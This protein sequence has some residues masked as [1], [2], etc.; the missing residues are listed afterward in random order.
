MKLNSISY[1]I[2]IYKT[3]FDEL[4]RC[5][6]HIKYQNNLNN[7]EIQVVLIFDGP[8]LWYG[9]LP[10]YLNE[11]TNLGI[12]VI[13]KVLESNVGTFEARKLGFLLSTGD[14]IFELDPD[15]TLCNTTTDTVLTEMNKHKVDLYA[16]TL[17]DLCFGEVVHPPKKLKHFRNYK[18]GSKITAGLVGT[19]KVFTKFYSTIDTPLLGYIFSEDVLAEVF[20]AWTNFR[21]YGSKVPSYIYYSEGIS[22]NFS[23]SL[24]FYKEQIDRTI[25]LTK[26]Y[27]TK[28]EA[29]KQLCT[30]L[31]EEF[32]N[33]KKSKEVDHVCIQKH[34]LD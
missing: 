9:E 34:A 31:Y 2:P 19:R 25:E 8:Y 11:L 32:Y 27:I 17:I 33:I 10:Q 18:N 6:K 16:Y 30:R 14:V 24:E 21:Y 23:K 29:Y 4:V 20:F 26:K 13:S 12:N 1:I 3:N 22:N 28:D 7:F 15:D 5:L